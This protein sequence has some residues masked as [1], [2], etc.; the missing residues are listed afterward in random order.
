MADSFEGTARVRRSPARGARTLAAAFA[1]VALASA[2]SDYDGGG[3]YT[4][5]SAGSGGGT[6]GGPTGPT[7]S[8]Q[9]LADDAERLLGPTTAAMRDSI[10]DFPDFWVVNGQ[11]SGLFGGAPAEVPFSV[12]S[13]SLRG[14]G[15]R[16][17]EITLDG[18][19]YPE[20]IASS[21]DGSLYIGSVALNTVV[22][23]PANSTTPEPFVPAGVAVAGV[24]GMKVD[25]DRGLLWLCDSDPRDMPRTGAV[26]GVSLDD[27]SE[28]VRH[29]L[30]APGADSLFCNDLEIDYSNG[31]VWA[32]ESIA[33]IIYRI[34]AADV[35]TPD[36][37][38]IWMRGGL[39]A[40]P[41]GGFGPNGL[42]LAGDTLFV[43]NTGN[44]VLFAVDTTSDDPVAD[45][46]AVTLREGDRTGVSLCGPDG[47]LAVLGPTDGTDLVV[48]EN[49]GCTAATPRVV[50]IWLDE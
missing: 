16:A 15:I 4:V 20:G 25:A 6:G 40:P 43:T 34:D 26:V 45:A 42:L 21:W 27:G 30:A 39:A 17:T 2:C 37:A 36:S 47:L 9:V 31:D 29:V 35:M 22:R 32:T 19:F 49:G 50:R 23:V 28:V 5:S 8:I 18:D 13:V 44:G 1:G 12:V 7:G 48:V 10:Y 38:K 11:L 14:G 3:S 46:R 41:A 33:G 24:I